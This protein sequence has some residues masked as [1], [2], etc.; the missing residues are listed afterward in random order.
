MQCCG[1][2]AV[3]RDKT[4]GDLDGIRIHCPHCGIY[5][6]S[7]TVLDRFLRLTLP[8][9]AEVLARAKRLA[10]PRAMPLVDA[11]CV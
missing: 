3:A 6:V 4:P 5:E 11:R 10:D 1:C 8:E 9:R 2:G 7:G